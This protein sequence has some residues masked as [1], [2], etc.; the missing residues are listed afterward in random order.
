MAACRRIEPLMASYWEQ[1]A[2]ID[3]AS[4]RNDAAYAMFTAGPDM[5]N[6]DAYN[7]W[8]HATAPL[9]Y[10]AWTETERQHA[11]TGRFDLAAAQAFFGVEPPEDL[12]ARISQALRG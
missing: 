1:A 7:A 8:R 9:G 10:A 3:P 2:D 5:S 12:A 4:E 11:R 6:E